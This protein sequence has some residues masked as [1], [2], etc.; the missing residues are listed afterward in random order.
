MFTSAI[1]GLLRH[2]LALVAGHLGGAGTS[3]A[4]VWAVAALLCTAAMRL[5]QDQEYCVAV[6]GLRGADARGR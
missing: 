6:L 5:V 4:L 2:G 3:V 1:T